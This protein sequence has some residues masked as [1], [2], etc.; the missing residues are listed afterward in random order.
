[1]AYPGGGCSVVGRTV[2]SMRA[3]D[4]IRAVELLRTRAEGADITVLGRGVSGALGLYAAVL[5]E[6]IGHVMLIDPPVTH[7]DGPILLN[8]LRYTDLP[9]VAALLAS[10][11][12]TFY[13]A[14]PEEFSYT[15]RA[16]DALGAS[17][18]FAL[19]MS[20]RASLLGRTGHGFPS[21][22]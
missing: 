22:I 11:R 12:L 2:D 16:F 13:G 5:D 3:W 6:S 21:G 17:E 4:V 20:I 8:V 1:M 18:R 14:V 19:S 15:R 7:R 10:R 9:E